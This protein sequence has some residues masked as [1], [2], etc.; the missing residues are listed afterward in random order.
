MRDQGVQWSHFRSWECI[1]AALAGD[2]QSPFEVVLAAMMGSVVMVLCRSR[3]VDV[4]RV[5]LTGFLAAGPWMLVLSA[6]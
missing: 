6:H 4:V 2:A 3:Q 5:V 1:C